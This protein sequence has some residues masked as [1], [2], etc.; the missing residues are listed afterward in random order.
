MQALSSFGPFFP[1]GVLLP[2]NV[3]MGS[4]FSE[5]TFYTNKGFS[6][7]HG[8]LVTLHKN[9][10]YGL[11]FDM[12]YTWSH[13]IDNVSVIANAPAVG[14]YGFICDVARPRECRA[15]SDFDATHYLNGTFIY[16]LP[17]GRG[18]AFGSSAPRWLDEIVG[19]WKLSGLPSWHSGLPYFF[20]TNAFVAGYA[21]NAPAILTGPSSDLDIRING[22][23]GQALNA[24]ADPNKAL[25]DFTD[26]LG[27]DIGARNNLRAPGYFDL[28]M[29]LGKSFPIT[30]ERLV[31]KFRADAFNVFNHPNFAAPNSDLTSGQFGVI[32][33]TV[34]TG[35]NNNASS[36]RVLQL[37]LRL[38]F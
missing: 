1:S 32:S 16:D 15:N 5:N 8:L 7:Y 25:G 13:S 2:P 30:A 9:L 23:K 19:G 3:G 12:N 17:F 34:G 22:G 18:K 6:A 21:N 27:F 38:E 4:Q 20:T 26:P 10:G 11:Q 36:A 29:G 37:A 24:Y 33:S 28:D 31:L 35:I 14:G